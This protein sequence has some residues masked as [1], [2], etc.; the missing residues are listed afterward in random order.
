MADTTRLKTKK[1]TLLYRPQI[2]IGDVIFI[3]NEEYIC[4][5]CD[6]LDTVLYKRTNEISITNIIVIPSKD[7]YFK[8][9]NSSKEELMNAYETLMQ[10]KG[11]FRGRNL[12]KIERTM[13]RML[14]E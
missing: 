13:K 5:Y 12:D 4:L 11:I 3:N 2:N 7:S 9:G 8:S 10:Y 1:T 6:K 14:M